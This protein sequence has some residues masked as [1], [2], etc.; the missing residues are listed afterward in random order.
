MIPTANYDTPA[1]DWQP[2]VQAL[3]VERVPDL[4]LIGSARLEG[5][6]DGYLAGRLVGYCFGAW[7]ALLACGCFAFVNWLF[8]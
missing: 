5:W 2:P 4:G 1:D 3:R 7:H 6:R 8:G